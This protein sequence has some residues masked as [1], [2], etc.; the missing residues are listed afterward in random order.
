MAS[1]RCIARLFGVDMGFFFREVHV[2][3]CAYRRKASPAKKVQDCVEA[4][5]ASELEK[6]IFADSLLA[7]R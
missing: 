6:Q 7:E 1:R 5:I 4:R 3:M 2:E